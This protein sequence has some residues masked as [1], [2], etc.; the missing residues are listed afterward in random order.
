[1]SLQ[2]SFSTTVEATTTELTYP[3][4][5]RVAWDDE[6]CPKTATCLKLGCNSASKIQNLFPCKQSLLAEWERTSSHLASHIKPRRL[7]LELSL[8]ST[9]IAYVIPMLD[10][11]LKFP[12][13]D[14]GMCLGRGI[15]DVSLENFITRRALEVTGR[16]NHKI[17]PFPVERLPVELQ[18]K[19]LEHSGLLTPEEVQLDI[20]NCFKPAHSTVGATG[21]YQF[22]GARSSHFPTPRNLT[23]A[24][25]CPPPC[26]RLA[27]LFAPALSGYSI[28]RT[29]SC[30]IRVL[31]KSCSVNQAASL[32][33]RQS[34]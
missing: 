9:D 29:P 22:L 10:A 25:I 12:L 15:R 20:E 21:G 8:G 13:A 31:N 3:S 32:I 14:C 6:Y 7:H 34:V 5:P 2:P 18:L 26:S 30:L 24:G 1:M 27:S 11:L 28:P 16:A 4:R 19:V 23:N 33:S 17:S